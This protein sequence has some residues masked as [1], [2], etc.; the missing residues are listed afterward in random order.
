MKKVLLILM[1]ALTST[2]ISAAGTAMVTFKLDN[3]EKG[4]LYLNGKKA[5]EI[6][7]GKLDKALAEGTYNVV[8]RE[9]LGDGSYYYYSEKVELFDGDMTTITAKMQKIYSEEYY[10][11]N[12]MYKEYLKIYPNG[13]YAAQAKSE[14]ANV[15]KNISKNMIIVEGGTL[16]SFYIGKYEV[17]QKEWQEVMGNNPSN[18]TG[19]RNPVENVSWYDAVAYCNKLSEMAGLTKYYNI[20]DTNVTIIGGK[21]YRLPTDAEWE[22]AARGGNKSAGYKYSGSN[23]IDEVAEYDNKSTKPVGGRKANELGLYDMSG[24]VYEW[25]Y[26]CYGYEDSQRVFRGGSF[27]SSTDQ[28]ILTYRKSNSPYTRLELIGFRLAR[29]F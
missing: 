8:I 6:R 17:T 4:I 9:E 14:S 18:F 29:S 3:R 20:I 13:K 11:K 10:I 15:I 12:Q 19:E 23:N 25:C 16:D 5:G 21:G 1:L 2:L 7:G 24:N 27:R 26:N 28:C 22:F